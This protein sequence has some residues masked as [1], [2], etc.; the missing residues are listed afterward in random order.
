M[1][2]NCV[3]GR[4]NI[5]CIYIERCETPRLAN[6]DERKDKRNIPGVTTEV[7]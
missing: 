5:I 3:C 6:E 4:N 2:A 7:V 1:F